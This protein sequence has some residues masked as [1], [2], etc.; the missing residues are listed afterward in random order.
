MDNN[1]NNRHETLSEDVNNRIGW[2]ALQ[3]ALTLSRAEED[4]LKSRLRENGFMC[5]ATGTGGDD[6]VAGQKII[7]AATGAALNEGLIEK[8]DTHLHAVIHATLD[9]QEAVLQKIAT[10]VNVVLKI[11]IVKK[12]NWVAVA[13]YGYSA[14]HSI[15]N[16]ERAGLGLMHI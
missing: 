7:N 10:G 3:L 11:A 8:K 15:T 6:S 9:A 4:H 2:A 5:T 1:N 14:A 13:M 16:H 12:G